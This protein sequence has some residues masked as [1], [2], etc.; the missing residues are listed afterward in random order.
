VQ[1]PTGGDSP[2]VRYALIW[3][4]SKTDSTV[5]MGEEWRLF[6]ISK[7]SEES[8]GCFFYCRQPQKI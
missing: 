7:Q 3:W 8:S 4:N 1:F 5:W 6:C 2:R